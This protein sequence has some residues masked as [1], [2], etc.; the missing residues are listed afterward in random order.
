ME[1]MTEFID[2][3]E[4]Y[5][6]AEELDCYARTL[7]E[8]LEDAEV[9]D[10]E[11]EK[12]E[13]IIN[14][15]Y[16]P[17]RMYL[18]DIGKLSLLN[19]TGE[20]EQAKQIEKGRADLMKVIFSVPLALERL[21]SISD[22]L[23][24]RQKP[25]GEF[26][27]NPGSTEDMVYIETEKFLDIISCIRKLLKRPKVSGQKKGLNRG[28]GTATR[29][30]G[31]T[32]DGKRE[33][34]GLVA[35]IKLKESIL[36]G[37]LEEI[38]AA[39]KRTEKAQ[40]EMSALSRKIKRSNRKDTG[41]V[42]CKTSSR[43]LERQTTISK[44]KADGA[45]KKAYKECLKS[46]KH[47]EAIIGIS[48]AEMKKTIQIASECRDR[49]TEAKHEMVKANLRLVISIAKRYAGK[50]L[51]LADLIQEGN[52]GLMRAVDK[53]EH[54]R[55][56]KFST[57]ATWWVRQTITRALSDHSRTIRIPVHMGDV[58][59]RLAKIKKA[60]RQETGCEPCAE[61]I[62]ER[63]NLPLSKVKTIM[64]IATE[65]LSIDAPVSEVDDSSLADLIEDKSVPSPL[66]RFIRFDLK[67]Q[68][69]AALSSLNAKEEMILRQRFGIGEVDVRTLEELGQ[70][71]E[72]TRERVRQIEIK[73][74]NKLRLPSRSSILKPFLER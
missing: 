25:L 20:I 41:A 32:G 43:S 71:L 39:V 36:H 17:L 59:S 74:I 44:L 65:P 47:E 15:G 37:L 40:A 3:A 28:R 2:D 35:C 19:R 26:L 62:A 50:G 16:E 69:E 24:S 22:S 72:V 9:D 11:D 1:E 70:E 6:G 38:G 5:H 12:E 33:I 57:Y 13:A 29:Y 30:P 49:I 45:M 4:E 73:A 27:I 51:G 14:Y 54:E 58:I 31:M 7:P 34:L 48:L 56:Y 61:D 55:G 18:G 68:I 23:I 42:A 64:M 46:I 8:G 52:I 21:L 53:F 10:I 60:C 66:D 67:K 63:I